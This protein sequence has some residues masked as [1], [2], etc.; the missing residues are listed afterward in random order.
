MCGRETDCELPLTSPTRSRNSSSPT[1]SDRPEPESVV[2]QAS[3][4]ETAGSATVGDSPA[5]PF[6]PVEPDPHAS[7]SAPADPGDNPFA[8]VGAPDSA[9][10]WPNEAYRLLSLLLNEIHADDASARAILK[11][12]LH[13]L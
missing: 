2:P 9:D 5:A 3:L 8:A 7:S 6:M 13:G 4:A 11:T 1:T 10:K 12:V